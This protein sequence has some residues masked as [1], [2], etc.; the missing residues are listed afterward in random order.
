MGQEIGTLDF[1]DDDFEKFGI[2]P[3]C[4]AEISICSRRYKD[5]PITKAFGAFKVQSAD[6][7]DLSAMHATD[8]GE[9]HAFIG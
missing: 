9:T 7:T 8:N 3:A 2:L 1:L 6:M 5:T 4:V